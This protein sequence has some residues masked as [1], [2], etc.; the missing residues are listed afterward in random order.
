[1]LREK[2]RYDGTNKSIK[3]NLTSGNDFTGEQD[4]INN[5]ILGESNTKINTPSDGEKTRYLPSSPLSLSFYFYDSYQPSYL[6]QG[7][8]L[9]EITNKD[10][11]VLKSFYVIQ[12]FDSKNSENQT[13]L[14]TGYFNGNVWN[15]SGITSIYNNLNDEFEFTNIYL[16]NNFIENTT[17]DT[18]YC[19]FYFYNSKSGSFIPFFNNTLSANTTTDRVYFDILINR[20]N[21]SYTMNSVV[22][23]ENNNANYKS[24]INNRVGSQPNEKPTYPTGDYFRNT[25]DYDYVDN[26]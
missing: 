19:L 14:H 12:I 13:L 17:G 22:A 5:F 10:Q 3:I 15:I 6:L 1:M 16:P 21:N 25:G 20:S 8:S 7:F 26:I 18:L 2:I 9:S 11:S 4:S 24:K 23:Y